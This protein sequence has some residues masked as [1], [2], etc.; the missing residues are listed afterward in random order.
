MWWLVKVALVLGILLVGQSA[1]AFLDGLRFLR[2]VRGRRLTPLGNLALP[3][4]VV[5][6]CKG[7]DTGFDSNFDR[8]LNQDYPDYWIVFTVAT[9]YDAAYSHLRALLERRG[10]SGSTVPPRTTL[11][12]AGLSDKRGE[13]VNNLLR[14]VEAVDRSVQV[15]VFADIDMAPS[16]RWLRS[17]VGPLADPKVTVSTGFRWYLPGEGFVS[18]L[19][20]A[21]DTSIATMMREVDP[22]FAWGGSMA[23]RSADFRRLGIAERYWAH[24]VSDDYSLTRAVR[25]ARGR[26]AFEPCCLVASREESSLREFLQWS[27]RQIVITRVYA[28]HL[29]AW[30]LATYLFYCGTLALG[31]VALAL[32]GPGVSQ[33]VLVAI[34]LSTVLLL[35]AGKGYVRSVVAREIFPTEISGH[36]SCYWLL[37]PL[38]PWVM[39]WNSVRAA[40][41]RRIRWRGTE[42]ELA[43]QDKVRVVGRARDC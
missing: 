10:A 41:T 32:P 12:V 20:A 36:A 15:L 23:I 38:V 2:Q 37:S 28:A 14:G 43:S 3:A 21:W 35:G 22:P 4:A 25:E 5:V 6:P 18:W 8:L 11:V 13:K 9:E 24:T 42:Y 30:G 16:P 1:W 19:R 26:I 39:L 27:T 7:V 29:W 34:T 17:L 31:L 33:R 40:F